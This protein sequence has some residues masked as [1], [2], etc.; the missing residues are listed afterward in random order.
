MN[1]SLCVP[2]RAGSAL[3]EGSEMTVKSGSKPMSS[4]A[5]GRM[6]RLRAN[7][8]CHA[9]SETTRTRNRYRGSAQANTSCV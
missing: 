8:L 2:S 3:N 6:N 7:R 9:I 5:F 1:V 4:S